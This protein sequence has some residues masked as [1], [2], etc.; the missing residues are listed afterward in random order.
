[1]KKKLLAFETVTLTDTGIVRTN[2]EDRLFAEDVVDLEGKDFKSYGIY[3]VADGMGGHQAGEIASDIAVKSISIII[4]DKLETNEKISDPN[5]LIAAAVEKANQEIYKT[6]TT[7]P[8][9]FT[10]GTTVTLG[11]RLDERLY[12][13]HVGDSRAY[14]VRKNRLHQ[15][16]EDHSLVARLVKERIITAE[17]AKTHPDRNKI[18]RCLGIMEKV[19]VDSYQKVSGKKW[20]SLETGDILLFCS[21]GLS[22]YVSNAEILKCLLLP[23]GLERACRELVNLANSKGGEDNITII[24]VRANTPPKKSPEIKPEINITRRRD[25]NITEI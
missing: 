20:L 10:M 21:D 19:A 7:S 9:L 22:G 14:L 5:Q 12:I 13:G 1:L 24:A 4:K 11:L 2:N 17:E 16:T 25:P 3:I 23:D 18:F 15:L 6:A 8:E